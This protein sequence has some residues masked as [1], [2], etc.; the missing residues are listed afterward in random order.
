MKNRI[1]WAFSLALLGVGG[2][3]VGWASR[4]G[5]PRS[6]L[7]DFTTPTAQY[8]VVKSS[9]VATRARGATWPKPGVLTPGVGAAPSADVAEP[10]AP[11]APL[12]TQ[13]ELDDARASGHA[14]P[15]VA[16]AHHLDE[17]LYQ[18]PVNIERTTQI[19]NELQRT[20]SSLSLRAR[21]EGATCSEDV[22]RVVVVHAAAEQRSSELNTLLGNGPLDGQVLMVPRPAPDNESVLYFSKKGTSLPLGIHADP[23]LAKQTYGAG[24]LERP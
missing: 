24:Q 1:G 20:A 2:L 15:I 11:P 5:A 18:Q 19:E 9:P 14:F 10:S 4:G 8:S 12:W 23:E 16:D 13:K 7:H 17:E 6:K 22:C 3:G 21:F